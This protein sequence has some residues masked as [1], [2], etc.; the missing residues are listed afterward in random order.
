MRIKILAVLLVAILAGSVTIPNVFSDDQ[1]SNKTKD[2]DENKT[3]DNE[4]KEPKFVFPN[5]TS[6]NFTL[7]NGTKIT[8]DLN[9]TNVGQMISSFIHLIHDD[10]KDQRNQ[11][12]QIIK[13]CREQAKNATSTDQR[14]NIMNDCKAQLKQINQ[15]FRD[16]H[17]QFQIVFK[18]F[19]NLVIDSEK[20]EHEKLKLDQ[21]NQKTQ[22]QTQNLE[23]KQLELQQKL[24]EKQDKLK[25]QEQNQEEKITEQEQK[26]Q[27]NLQHQEEKL[28]E[29]SQKS[30]G[31]NSED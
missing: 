22:N 31:N 6:F 3:G 23:E 26:L 10:F 9:G 27:E 16:E 11:S 19:R 30:K 8:F 25:E 12:M 15:K 5:A 2:H 7:P 20:Q 13:E 21:L 17:K 4:T 24:Q 18:D 1:D 29:K 14:K 28:K